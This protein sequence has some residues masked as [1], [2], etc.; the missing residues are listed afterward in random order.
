MGDA[1][2]KYS[3]PALEKGLDILELL[4]NEEA[5]LSLS[6]IARALSRS[7]GEIFRMLA[8]LE[9]RGYV[10]QDSA[11]GRYVL[12]T[13]LFEL[14]HRLPTVRRLTALA[15]P[16]MQVL[17]REI[18]Q[19]VH[20]AIIAGNE[21]LVVGQT[22]SPTDNVMSVRLGAKIELC[23]AS[24]GRVVMAFLPGEEVDALLGGAPL[25]EGVSKAAVKR[26]LEKIRREGYE[27]RDSFVVRGIVNLSAP[28]LDHSGKAIAALTVPH[29]KRKGDPV[30]FE[31][32]V[33]KLVGA[34]RELGTALGARRAAKQPGADP[35]GPDSPGPGPRAAKGPKG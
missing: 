13:F 19:S 20:L 8:A 9:H 25:P 5:G 14:A 28:V 4:S 34:A 27:V 6:E 26:D 11:S 22:D 24:S 18:G 21:V 15:G 31:T 3:V 23:N 33:E 17:A 30:E 7:V 16:R 2:R 35:S 1:Q 12:T 32:C 10:A 29:I